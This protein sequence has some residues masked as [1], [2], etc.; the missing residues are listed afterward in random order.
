M[1]MI[2]NSSYSN[3]YHYHIEENWSQVQEQIR[4]WM[5]HKHEQS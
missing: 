5:V 1:K 3:Y 4:D 2:Q